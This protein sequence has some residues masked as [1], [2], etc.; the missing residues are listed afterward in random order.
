MIIIAVVI[1]TF[2]F[3]FSPD[4]KW[5]GRGGGDADLG[6][7]GG[8]PIT[9]AEYLD[10]K[11][12]ATLRYFVRTGNWPSRDASARQLGFDLERDTYQ[13]V[14]LIKKQKELNIQPST[15]AVG[16]LAA[17]LLAMMKLPYDRF[18]K[19]VLR[20]EGLTSADFERYCRHEAGLLHLF[21]V[22]GISGKLVPPREAELMYRQEHEEVVVETVFFSASNY[23]ASVAIITNDLQQFY[24]NRVFAYRLPERVQVSYVIFDLTNFFADADKEMAKLTNL[25]QIVDAVYLRRGTNYFKGTN[26]Q[27]LAE[28]AAKEKIRQEIYNEHATI[29]ARKKANTFASEL[30]EL[31][32]QRADNLDKLAA[33]RGYTVKVTEP[34]DEIDGPAGLKVTAPFIRNSFALSDQEPFA[35]PVVT[36]DGVYVIALKKKLPS[37]YPPFEGVR[38]KVTA[39]YRQSK[40]MDLARQAADAFNHNLTN[41][42]AQGKTFTAVCLENKVTPVA[43]LPFSM[44]SRDVPELGNRVNLNLLKTV[45]FG[46]VPGK[47]SS[48]VATDDGGMFVFLRN[49]LPVDEPKMRKEMTEFIVSLRQYRQNQ[50]FNEW[51]R[52]QIEQNPDFGQ[53][54]RRLEK[55]NT[56]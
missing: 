55:K 50:A 29:A 4:V 31:K 11:R 38:G 37:E 44:S 6:S 35:P 15:T 8:Q 39:D 54:L 43:L 14:F 2:V 20:Q 10:A 12:E 30:F 48:F 27:V 26:N 16:Q 56:T 9:A 3:M 36:E 28:T 7:I 34:F 42:L 49:R 22:A 51:F 18:V 53:V 46:L 52:K 24:T 19:E 40:A 33:G 45:A 1:I 21:E 17:E 47:A 13:R 5:G 41:S 32:P 25:N 23:L